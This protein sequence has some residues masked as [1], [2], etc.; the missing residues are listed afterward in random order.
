MKKH[1][2][3]WWRDL[4]QITI[5]RDLWE[6]E[7]WWRRRKC[8]IYILVISSQARTGTVPSRLQLQSNFTAHVLWWRQ[9]RVH[10]YHCVIQS[11]NCNTF[12]M[13]IQILRSNQMLQESL[14]ILSHITTNL[15]E[16]F[17]YEGETVSRTFTTLIYSNIDSFF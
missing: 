3:L 6:M 9:C 16:Q 14:T 5:W 8:H 2:V 7:V 13:V 11:I 4:V 10:T 12:M 1:T 15:K 17:M